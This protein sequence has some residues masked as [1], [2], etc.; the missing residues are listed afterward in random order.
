M[1]AFRF[2]PGPGPEESNLHGHRKKARGRLPGM[3]A[4]K[5]LCKKLSLYTRVAPT[6]FRTP[7]REFE[8]RIAPAATNC[9]QIEG[10]LCCSSVAAGAI[11]DSTFFAGQGRFLE[12]NI[13]GVDNPCVW[14]EA[15]AQAGALTIPRLQGDEVRGLRQG[16]SGESAFDVWRAWW[17]RRARP[18]KTAAMNGSIASANTATLAT[19]AANYGLKTVVDQHSLDIAANAAGGRH[20][21]LFCH[22]RALGQLPSVTKHDVTH[23]ETNPREIRMLALYFHSTA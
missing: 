11:L 2:F 12:I 9:K 18:T 7:Q 13:V 19:V 1:E 3:E 6:I 5:F 21:G 22:Q 4:F 16:R 14:R 23:T 8:S 15:L 17:P 20:Q 10:A